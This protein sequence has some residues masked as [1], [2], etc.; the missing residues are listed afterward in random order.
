MT[1]TEEETKPVVSA[2]DFRLPNPPE[3]HGNKRLDTLTCAD[4]VALLREHLLMRKLSVNSAAAVH[5]SCL[6]LRGPALTWKRKLSSEDKMPNN[7]DKF[8]TLLE[9]AFTPIA[10][11]VMARDRLKRLRQQGPLEKY[12]DMF[13]K[14]ALLVKDMSARDKVELFVDNLFPSLR[15]TVRVHMLDKA[16][17]DLELAMRVSLLLDYEIKKDRTNRSHSHSQS[18]LSAL[19]TTSVVRK[20]YKCGSTEH[21][22]ANFPKVRH[23][24]K[25]NGSEGKGKGKG[26]ESNS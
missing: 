14:Q 23:G 17:D 20:C 26:K 18:Q 12:C 13:R 8:A 6:F 3:F 4:W 21:L 2:D 19:P 25:Y 5:F 24:R 11:A 22:H 1:K 16:Q 7:F 9:E 15:Q 10:D